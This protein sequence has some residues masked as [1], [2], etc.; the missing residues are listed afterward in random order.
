MHGFKPGNGRLVWWI[1]WTE[2]TIVQKLNKTLIGECSITKRAR[3]C[4]PG[5]WTC[6]EHLWLVMSDAYARAPLRCPSVVSVSMCVRM[7][8][9]GR[10]RARE[11]L[12]RGQLKGYV[13]PP[14]KAPAGGLSC[15]ADPEK[16]GLAWVGRGTGLDWERVLMARW[17][18]GGWGAFFPG[19]T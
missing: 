7:C 2:L 14:T 5:L 4:Q 18:S 9:R 10:E 3:L 17:A 6:L 11:Q 15:W 16:R 19:M 12:C 1:N 13:T 8:V